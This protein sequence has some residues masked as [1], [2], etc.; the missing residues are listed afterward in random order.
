MRKDSQ[1]MHRL[2]QLVSLLIGARI[3]MLVLHASALYVSTF[4]II[5]QE[6][7]LRQFVF[8]YKIH[9]IVLCSILSIAAGGI[10]NQFYDLEKDRV[11]KPFVFRLQ[12]FLKQ[13][14]F[15]YTYVILALVSLVISLFLSE[16]IFIFFLIYQFLIWLYSHKL[17][18]RVVINNLAFVSL[19]LYPFFGMLV[20]YQ[21]FSILLFLMA[22]FLFVILLCVDILKDVMTLRPDTLFDYQTFPSVLGI[23]KTAVILAFLS[24]L[25]LILGLLTAWKIGEINFLSVYFILSSGVFLYT[26]IRLKTLRIHQMHLLLNLLRIWIFIGVIFMLMGGIYS[27]L[28]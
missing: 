5:N 11:Q 24:F 6:E 21:H 1:W 27:K 15:L 12:S 3:F 23:K 13:K 25:G 10:I 7:N 19:T 2:S 26:L 14:Y 22:A 16:R 17:S 9:G 4:F 20:Y 28:N 18:K 8:D